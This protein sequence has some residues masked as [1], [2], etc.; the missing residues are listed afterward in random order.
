MRQVQKLFSGIKKIVASLATLA[1]LLNPSISYSADCEKLFENAEKKIIKVDNSDNDRNGSS[2]TEE[3]MAEVDE[4]LAKGY[5]EGELQQGSAKTE[6]SSLG[7]DSGAAK[8]GKLAESSYQGAAKQ[9]KSR[10]QALEKTLQQCQKECEK[11]EN[12]ERCNK[13]QDESMELA[14]ASD[15]ASENA[16]KSGKA[17]NAMSAQ[18][19]GAGGGGSGGGGSTKSADGGGG[20]I[21]QFLGLLGPLLGLLG[22]GGSQAPQAPQ[23]AAAPAP[24]TCADPAFAAITLACFCTEATSPRYNPRDPICNKGGGSAALVLPTEAGRGGVPIIPEPDE[25]LGGE[26]ASSIRGQPSKGNSD[27]LSGG[28]GGGIGGG[29]SAGPLG[30]DHAPAN[31]DKGVD[32]NVIT[33]QSGGQPGG[34]FGGGSSGGPGLAP[35]GG[36]GGSRFASF[37]ERFNLSK[38]IPTKKDFQNRGIAGMSVP[39]VDGMT[40]PNGPSI[41]EKNSRAYQTEDGRGRWIRGPLLPTANTAAQPAAPAQYQ[42]SGKPR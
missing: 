25:K 9:Y 21:G 42:R 8:S 41:W 7:K 32:K 6:M 13:I 31:A 4:D 23:V 11:P 30:Q 38:F 20:D 12:E 22:G 18:N 33:G 29:G 3:A 35:G 2:A 19:D 34:G 40:G 17:A 16:D 1:L 14:K 37:A 15:D 10:H 28:G 24:A 36:G 5:G 39:S 26:I 27:G